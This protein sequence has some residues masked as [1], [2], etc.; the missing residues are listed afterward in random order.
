MIEVSGSLFSVSFYRLTA[1]LFFYVYQSL[2]FTEGAYAVWLNRRRLLEQKQGSRVGLNEQ[3]P[4]FWPAST[5]SI[6]TWPLHPAGLSWKQATG[7]LNPVSL[8][9]G[10]KKI[11]GSSK[12]GG[13]LTKC[14]TTQKNV[15]YTGSCMTCFSIAGPSWGEEIKAPERERWEPGR[16]HTARRLVFQHSWT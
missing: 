2:P 11:R 10:K 13:G 5:Y 3:L 4:L 7:C 14:M 8:A 9:D 12:R 1:D 15:M 6:V 16:K